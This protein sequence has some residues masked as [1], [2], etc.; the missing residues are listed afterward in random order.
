MLGLLVG[1][2]GEL[3]ALTLV[4]LV[5]QGALWANKGGQ[6][7]VTAHVYRIA[8]KLSQM[9]RVLGVINKILFWT[10]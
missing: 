4:L 3:D 7:G 6:G 5:I 9:I 1:N 10:F 8:T 2:P